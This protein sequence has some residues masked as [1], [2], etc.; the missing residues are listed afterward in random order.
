MQCSFHLKV[1]HIKV[2]PSELSVED[3]QEQE[4]FPKQQQ[5]QQ[6]KHKLLSQQQQKQASTADI[7][8]RQP[9]VVP[10]S[11]TAAT[12][13]QL[14]SASVLCARR[15]SVRQSRSSDNAH[16]SVADVSWDE[17]GIRCACV[18]SSKRI[19][20]LFAEIVLFS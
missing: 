9:A 16:S 11:S 3:K 7:P 14:P 15:L 6:Q 1:S 18:Y 8:S 2:E 17:V 4:N 12:C 20:V 13:Q 19:V 10:V 5:Q